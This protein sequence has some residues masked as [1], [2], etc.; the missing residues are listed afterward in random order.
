[1]T[2]QVLGISLLIAALSAGYQI[3]SVWRT[4][5]SSVEERLAP[6][7]AAMCPRSRPALN[8]DREQMENQLQGIAQIPGVVFCWVTGDLPFPS[9][10]VVA[11]RWP[12]F[13]ASQVATGAE[14]DLGV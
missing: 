6:F 1:M 11:T 14:P 5:L 8:L 3:Y 7:E 2:L 12:I 4:G 10:Q 13:S 9:S